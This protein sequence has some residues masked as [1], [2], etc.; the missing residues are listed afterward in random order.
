MERKSME[1]NDYFYIIKKRIWLIFSVTL[2][3][4]SISALVSFFLLSPTY[5]AKID[6]LIN[7]SN[8][9]VQETV[10][11][12]DKDNNKDNDKNSASVKTEQQGTIP[13]V[14]IDS[15]LKLIETYKTLITS[16]LIMENV[17]K[18]IGGSI[19]LENNYGYVAQKQEDPVERITELVNVES[20][21]DSQLISITAKHHNKRQSAL[22]ADTVADTFKKEVSTL[23]NVNNIQIVSPAKVNSVPISPNPILNISLAFVFGLMIS[24]FTA[25]LLKKPA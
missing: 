10:K 14:D 12:N 1:L 22:I 3:C 21:E 17:Y 11:D 16:P 7:N 9:V 6:L 4:T 19:A 13:V 2:L 23:M 15:N 18:E 5:E 25:F 24:L 20:V 8:E